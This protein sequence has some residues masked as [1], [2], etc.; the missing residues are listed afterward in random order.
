MKHSTK[1]IDGDEVN[2]IKDNSATLDDDLA[3]EYDLS[4]VE[5]KPNPYA[6]KLKEQKKITV[7]L[8]HDIAKYF[9]SSKEVNDYLRSQIDL[10]KSTIRL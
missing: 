8:D 4:K 5:L 6:R 1:T 7:K 10:L 3:E 9:K 2:V